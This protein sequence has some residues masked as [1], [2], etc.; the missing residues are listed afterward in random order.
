MFYIFLFFILEL[1]QE[2]IGKIVHNGLEKYTLFLPLLFFTDK[3]EIREPCLFLDLPGFDKGRV[4]VEDVPLMELKLE[5]F[6][7]AKIVVEARVAAALE[8]GVELEAGEDTPPSQAELEL[9][10]EKRTREKEVL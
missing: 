8:E 5:S 1:K 7:L 10:P 2:G 3:Q 4:V 9:P 6:D